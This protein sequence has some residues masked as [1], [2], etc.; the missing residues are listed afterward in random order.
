MSTFHLQ[1]VTPDG[2]LFDGQAE[3]IV[4]RTTEGDVC[5]LKSHADYVSAVATGAARITMDGGKQRIAACS[6]GLIS[7]KGDITR[8]AADTFEWAE[9]IDIERARRA[10]E[11]AEMALRKAVDFEYKAAELKLKRALTRIHVGEESK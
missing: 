9:N 1:I 4:V 7:V 6:G 11:R 2:L 10:K 3:K 8:L 5:I